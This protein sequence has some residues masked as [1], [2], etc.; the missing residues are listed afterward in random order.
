MLSPGNDVSPTRAPPAGRVRRAGEVARYWSLICV[1]A[2]TLSDTLPLTNISGVVNLATFPLASTASSAN[3]MSWV[4]E[5][6]GTMG[7]N[8]SLPYAIPCGLVT[9][10]ALSGWSPDIAAR[11]GVATVVMRTV[12]HGSARPP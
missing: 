1:I 11:F 8:A 3:W 10:V 2:T 4:P 6:V 5:A 9:T 12:R 7:Q